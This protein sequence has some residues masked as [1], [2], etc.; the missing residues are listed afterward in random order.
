[1]PARDLHPSSRGLTRAPHSLAGESS[2]ILFKRGSKAPIV[3]DAVGD[4]EKANVQD[5]TPVADPDMSAKKQTEQALAAQ[6]K[7]RDVFSW[8]DIEY[9]VTLSGNEQRRLLEDI[10]GYVLPGKLTALMGESGAGKVSANIIMLYETPLTWRAADYALKRPSR[11]YEH[12]CCARR[13]VRQ[14]ASLTC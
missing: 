2:V 1:M 7:M 3:Q 9:T 14:R 12:W 10:S 4:E 11:A 13:P 6:P 8:Q 5:F